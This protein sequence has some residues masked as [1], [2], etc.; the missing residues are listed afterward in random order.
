MAKFAGLIASAALTRNWYLP[1]AAVGV[2]LMTPALE[3]FNP[4][5]NVPLNSDHVNAFGRQHANRVDEKFC[6]MSPT[7]RS[8]L[9]ML[10]VVVP[11][12]MNTPR[13]HFVSVLPA[14]SRIRSVML[15]N[16][17]PS[18]L[19]TMFRVPASNDSPAGN[20]PS[21]MVAV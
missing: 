16:P 15:K 17:F 19:P 5:G 2:P 4:S 12:A 8:L 18:G 1:T 7:P 10:T 9:L 14:E 21:M 3:R 20:A 11:P 13:A 6:P